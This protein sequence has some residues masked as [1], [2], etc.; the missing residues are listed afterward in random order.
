MP[1]GNGFEAGG[2][3]VHEDLPPIFYDFPAGKLMFRGDRDLRT[4]MN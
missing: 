1:G 4:R 2:N 3:R